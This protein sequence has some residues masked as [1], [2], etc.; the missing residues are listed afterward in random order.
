MA[1]ALLARRTRRHRLARAT[2][3]TVPN[4]PVAPLPKHESVNA[5]RQAEVTI[6]WYAAEVHF[7]QAEY[8]LT[9]EWGL[10][11]LLA[12]QSTTN[13]VVIVDVLS[14]S[15]AVDIALSRGASVLPYRWNDGSAKQFAAENGAVLAGDRSAGSEYTLSPAS[16]RSMP[17]GTL[18]VLPSP[19]A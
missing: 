16:L 15:T 12:L 6:L 14:F 5:T 17:S 9:C 2:R 13:A 1:T 10:A 11:G 4:E 8:D 7:D 3:H 19:N 18:L